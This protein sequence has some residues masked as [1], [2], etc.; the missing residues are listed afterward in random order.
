MLAVFSNTNEINLFASLFPSNTEN[1]K[2]VY[3]NSKGMGD[4]RYGI[5]RGTDKSVKA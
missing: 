2:I 3:W 5:P 1:T 4:F